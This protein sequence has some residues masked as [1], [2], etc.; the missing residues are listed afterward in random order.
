MEPINPL[1]NSKKS[2]FLESFRTIHEFQR[3]FISDI[4]W[5]GN[6]LIC[7]TTKGIVY[8]YPGVL[9]SRTEPIK[10]D[11]NQITVEDSLSNY[12]ISNYSSRI[13]RVGISPNDPKLFLTLQNGNV[14]V[15]DLEK[16]QEPLDAKKVIWINSFY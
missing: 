16:P 10:F 3:P 5:K 15:W 13:H 9:E 6:T 4:S 7:G 1:S 14:Y 2:N 8:V 11:H 12:E